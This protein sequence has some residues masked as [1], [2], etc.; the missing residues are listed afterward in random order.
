M[1]GGPVQKNENWVLSRMAAGKNA[2]LIFTAWL[3]NSSD[4]SWEDISSSA[5]HP[6]LASMIAKSRVHVLV[7]RPYL[8]LMT[9][10]SIAVVQ[11]C[12]SVEQLKALIQWSMHT[13]TNS[14]I[15]HCDHI[16]YCVITAAHNISS[17]QRVAETRIEMMRVCLW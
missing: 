6:G 11:P 9:K 12:Q 10:D 15:M 17:Y 13:A 4:A 2:D 8:R 7:C 16:P 14:G 3:Y 5:M 1:L